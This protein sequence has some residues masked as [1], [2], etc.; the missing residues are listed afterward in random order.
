M[1]RGQRSII[2]IATCEVG[3]DE[4]HD[5]AAS[6]A[7]EDEAFA[8]AGLVRAEDPVEKEGDANLDPEGAVREEEVEGFRSGLCRGWGTS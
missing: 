2:C 6:Y 8:E 1:P 5:D 4:D 3:P 7:D